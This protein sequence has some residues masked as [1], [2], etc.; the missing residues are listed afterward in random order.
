[1]TRGTE[2]PV[3]TNCLLNREREEML[4]GPVPVLVMRRGCVTVWPST[5]VLK[6]KLEAESARTGEGAVVWGPPPAQPSKKKMSVKSQ[7]AGAPRRRTDDDMECCCKPN[8]M[9]PV[10]FKIQ[11]T[12]WPKVQ[13]IC[14]QYSYGTGTPTNTPAQ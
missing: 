2:G 8:K 10:N 14:P 5:T 7:A 6:S 1:M 4:R 3:M 12:A 9:P 13:A 11:I